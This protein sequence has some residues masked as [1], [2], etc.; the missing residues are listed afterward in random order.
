MSEENA[1]LEARIAALDGRIRK[2]RRMEETPPPR[3][4]D[5]SSGPFKNRTLVNKQDQPAGMDTTAPENSS[6]PSPYPVAN[7]NAAASVKAN[8]NAN[9]PANAGASANAVAAAA[10]Q[11]GSGFLTYRSNRSNQLMTVSTFNRE[12]IQVAQHTPATNAPRPQPSTPALG[13]SNTPTRLHLV[14]GIKFEVAED[15]SKLVRLDDPANVD[16]ETPKTTKVSGVDFRRTKHGNLVRVMP[17]SG[18]QHKPPC[19][20]FTKHGNYFVLPVSVL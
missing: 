19:K 8:V 10:P 18:D 9:A 17:A 14:E 4:N 13:T 11:A 12:Q 2:R 6:S 16:R 7:A 15:G 20:N 3:S 1:A 5:W